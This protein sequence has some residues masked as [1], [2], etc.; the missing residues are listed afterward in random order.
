MYN[1]EKEK[2]IKA[3]NTLPPDDLFEKISKAPVKKISAEEEL[4]SE[5]AEHEEEKRRVCFRIPAAI[6]SLAAVAV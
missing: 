6:G 3:F 1:R 4:F 2:L 5:L